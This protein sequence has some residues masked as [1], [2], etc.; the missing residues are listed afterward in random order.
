[1]AIALGLGTAVLGATVVDMPVWDTTAW[2]IAPA[3]AVTFGDG[4]I[5]F[6]AMPRL[7]SAQTTQNQ[8][9]TWGGRYYFTVD[10]PVGASEPLGQLVIQQTE[11]SDRL[12]R[13]DLDRTVAFLA[14]IARCASTSQRWT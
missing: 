8:A 6:A 3:Q 7:V 14:A 5:H 4:S 9:R 13:F 10:L 2:S 11:G 1:M 12:G